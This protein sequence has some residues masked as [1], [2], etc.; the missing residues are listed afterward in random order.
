MWSVWSAC[1]GSCGQGMKERV[2][3]CVDINTGAISTA[4]KGLHTMMEPCPLQ[5]CQVIGM[6]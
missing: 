6:T 1:R 5:P 2:R 3:D 4:C